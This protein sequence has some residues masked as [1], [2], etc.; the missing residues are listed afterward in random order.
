[1]RKKNARRLPYGYMM[2]DG[3][4]VINDTEAKVVKEIYTRC[5][6]KESL[7]SIS[8]FLFENRVD[9][10]EDDMKDAYDKICVIARDKRYIGDRGFP[11]ILTPDIF[12]TV[13]KS[14]GKQNR[15]GKKN[16]A[17]SSHSSSDNNTENK[18]NTEDL[19][20][21]FIPGMVVFNLED[22]L[23]E[24]LKAGNADDIK[25][26]IIELAA[27]KYKCISITSITGRT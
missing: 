16:K 17:T 14:K 7:Y 19:S 4:A 20:T 6:Q 3:K 5:S 23:R 24:Q 11:P 22:Q 25:S 1:M 15:G 8:K 9:Y 2:I 18:F 26:T 21:M 10:F 12:E 13:Q 27:E